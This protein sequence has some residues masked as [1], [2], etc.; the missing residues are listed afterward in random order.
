MKPTA[1]ARILDELKRCGDREQFDRCERKA[2]IYMITS[3]ILSIRKIVTYHRSNS[4]RT[5]RCFLNIYRDC[6]PPLSRGMKTVCR[7]TYRAPFHRRQDLHAPF[8]KEVI[9]SCVELLSLW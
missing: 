8:V 2:L 3:H 1:E 5:K 4:S 9:F 7:G 6:H